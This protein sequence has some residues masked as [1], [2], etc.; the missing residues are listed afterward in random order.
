MGVCEAHPEKHPQREA[1]PEEELGVVEQTLLAGQSRYQI[2]VT[3]LLE[4]PRN[5]D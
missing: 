2:P 3:V 4:N 1:Q 5:T